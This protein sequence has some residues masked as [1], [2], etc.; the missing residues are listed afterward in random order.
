MF[1][2]FKVL[3]A[4]ALAI[5][6][7]EYLRSCSSFGIF[8]KRNRVAI[9]EQSYGATME[10]QDKNEEMLIG[11]TIE[12]S[13]ADLARSR[14]QPQPPTQPVQVATVEIHRDVADLGVSFVGGCNTHPDFIDEACAH[15]TTAKDASLQS[16][17][18]LLSL[19]NETVQNIDHPTALAVQ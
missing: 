8:K 4:V 15:G 17:D 19:N 14:I 1:Y 12:P 7:V 6:A 5:F 11:S 9:H 13:A 3:Q 2:G 10:S 18:H 16:G